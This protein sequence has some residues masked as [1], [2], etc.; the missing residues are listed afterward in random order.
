MSLFIVLSSSPRD[1]E[2]YCDSSL[3][4]YDKCSLAPGGT[5]LG[6]SQ[7]TWAV[8]S[9]VG[10]HLPHPPKPII[11]TQSHGCYL[12]YIGWLGGRVVSVPDSGSKEHGFESQ[13]GSL[14]RVPAS[15][16]VKAESH[17]CRVAGNS[18]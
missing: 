4:S 10:C 11:I 7:K 8:S 17:L 15:A 12:F 3:E 2:S 5:T 18:V 16:G 14:N 1:C 13:S 6:L 9:P